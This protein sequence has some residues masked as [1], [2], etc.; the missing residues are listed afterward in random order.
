MTLRIPLRST[1]GLCD[2]H[3]N[4]AT[5]RSSVA[6][7]AFKQSELSALA[8]RCGNCTRPGKQRD[9]VGDYLISRC[10]MLPV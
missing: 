4:G 7:T 6:Q 5:V 8:T 10:Y 2:Y 3:S 1:A 9:I